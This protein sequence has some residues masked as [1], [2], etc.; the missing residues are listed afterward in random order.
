[1]RPSVEFFLVDA[2]TDTPSKG[3]PAAVCILPDLA[4]EAAAGKGA[5]A[6]TE[7]W[8]QSVASEMNISETA[9]LT[10][11][12]L[13]DAD[14]ISDSVDYNLRWFTPTVEVDL[15]GH[16]T[17]AAAHILWERGY[18][19]VGKGISFSTKSGVLTARRNDALI[20]L[21]FPADPVA[22]V[23][24]SDK[25]DRPDRPEKPDIPN[26]I[27]HALGA[28]LVFVGRGRE[29]YLIEIE[30]E[31]KLRS[32]SLDLGDITALK[33]IPIAVDG[34]QPR[35]FI[36]T[37]KAAATSG[38]YDFVSRFFAP[39]AGINED[40]VT[41]SAHCTL[42]G[43]WAGKLGKTEM[44]GYQAS[45]RGGF[46]NVRLGDDPPETGHSTVTLGGQAVTVYAGHLEG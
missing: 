18:V 27:A 33:K 1:M 30:S 38:G 32:L 44:T 22:E 9:F 13:D 4:D 37:A 12:P 39:A 36:V 28:V 17:L 3:N 7:P 34:F 23:V 29:D 6:F 15:C 5:E 10:K 45:E 20:E 35:G 42:A 40:P 26:I 41:G 14:D 8:M 31:K 46:V 16:A 21:E 19:E 2:F 24:F 25:S 11:R 43:Y